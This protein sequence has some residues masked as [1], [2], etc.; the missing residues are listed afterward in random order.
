[1]N[2]AEESNVFSSLHTYVFDKG[3][4]ASSGP[5]SC[6]PTSPSGI[7]K[8]CH[9]EDLLEVFSSSNV[10]GT[11]YSENGGYNSLPFN[12]YINDVWT[13]FIRTGDPQPDA[14]Y[15]RV[16]GRSYNTTLAWSEATPFEAYTQNSTSSIQ[17]LDGPPRHSGLL[18]VDQ[19][20]VLASSGFLYDNVQAQRAGS[21]SSNSTNTV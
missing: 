16:R 10:I 9:S 1:L 12:Q 19:C 6:G 2:I 14:E 8:V 20:R 17:I 21:G 3:V 7:D 15:L 13:S 11:P 18:N 5:A 4:L